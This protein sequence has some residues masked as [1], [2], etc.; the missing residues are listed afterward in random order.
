V[1]PPT[2]SSTEQPRADLDVEVVVP[3]GLWVRGR[4]LEVELSGQL[5]VAQKGTQPTVTG[6][7]KAQKGTLR[8]MGRS[9]D[10]ERGVVR[11]YGDDETNPALDIELAA[12]VSSTTVRI[13]ITGT[14]HQPELEL[15]SEPEMSEGDIMAVLVFGET[16]DEL[17]GDQSKLIAERAAAI[18]ATYGAQTLESSLSGPLKVDLLSYNP[19]TGEEG[20]GSV[21][22]GKYLSPKAL[23][24]YEQ[25]LDATT[26]FLVTLEYTLTR[27]F[28]LETLVGT[29][30]SG[31]ELRWS[32]DY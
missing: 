5:R 28:T 8:L 18:A 3:S 23:L 26:G 4:Q 11:F 24:K 29:Q 13:H 2:V 1:T 25:A 31:A 9:F 15:S 22:V 7:L 6:E 32:R 21:V 20:E 10:M 14:A 16:T 30:Q 27:S 19:A 17:D 12:K